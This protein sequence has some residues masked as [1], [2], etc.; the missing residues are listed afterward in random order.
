MCFVVLSSNQNRSA[1]HPKAL[2]RLLNFDR[3]INLVCRAKTCMQKVE[4][5]MPIM[6]YSRSIF[7]HFGTLSSVF[8]LQKDRFELTGFQCD[9]FFF[10]YVTFFLVPHKLRCYQWWECSKHARAFNWERSIKIDFP[11]NTISKYIQ[12]KS[13][14]LLLVENQIAK[15]NPCA[16]LYLCLIYLFVSR[17]SSTLVQI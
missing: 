6:I 9:F 3:G 7:C 5:A 8:C 14:L 17:F 12:F 2:P 4:S 10:F 16:F 11:L 1:V 15:L 13:V